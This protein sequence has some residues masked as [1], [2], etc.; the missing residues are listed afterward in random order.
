MSSPGAELPLEGE[1]ETDQGKAFADPQLKPEGLVRVGR[2]IDDRVPPCPRGRR[3]AG[4][5]LEP[6]PVGAVGAM[7]GRRV[8][9]ERRERRGAGGRRRG[10]RGGH[11][12][13]RPGSGSTRARGLGLA[14]GRGRRPR[15]GAHGAQ[16]GDAAGHRGQ[17]ARLP[18]RP[19][20]ERE[21][22]LERDHLRVDGFGLLLLPDAPR[23]A[24][25]GA[26][27]R[28]RN[29]PGHRTGR[30]G[31]DPT[32]RLFFCCVVQMATW[33]LEI[34]APMLWQASM[35][36]GAN[37]KTNPFR[38][39]SLPFPPLPSP[40]RR[41]RGACSLQRSAFWTTSRGRRGRR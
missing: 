14:A 37:N 29:R 5:G 13:G 20:G 12:S 28:R 41:C 23:L 21:D 26:H 3:P 32:G 15:R 27:W 38:P 2:V 19:A 33:S 17:G 7:A 35:A 8:L 22:V 18:G 34:N 4:S 9:W 11:G 1:G 30:R 31:D 16:G 39:V 40:S 36:G 25:V 24:F 6:P 10:G